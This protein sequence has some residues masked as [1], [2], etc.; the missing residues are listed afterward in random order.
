MMRAVSAIRPG[1]RFASAALGGW[2]A[3]CAGAGGTD[4]GEP[5]TAAEVVSGDSAGSVDTGGGVRGGSDAAVEDA[6]PA[7]TCAA[8]Q[9][10][11]DGL[12]VDKPCTAD[13]DCNP[14]DGPPAGGDTFY[15]P[16]GTCRAWQCA[17]DDHCKGGQKCNTVTYKCYQPQTGCSIDAQCVDD[18]AC[19][20]DTCDTETGNCAHAPIKGCCKVAADCD[21]QD[22]CTAETCSAG[23]CDWKDIAGCC[24]DAADCDDGD[25]CTTDSCASAGCK[26]VAA[27]GC[28]KSASQCNDADA[29]TTDTCDSK[30][31]S[32][33]HAL[34]GAPT[35]C[36]KAGDCSAGA[37]AAGACVGGVCS[38][39]PKGGATCCQSATTCPLGK[40]CAAPTCAAWACTT[41]PVSGGKEGPHVSWDFEGGLDGWTVSK[42]NATAFFHSSTLWAAHGTS[43]LRYGVPGKATWKAGLPNQGKALSPAFTVPTGA[44]LDA[45]VYF[46]G[47]PA[48]GVHL[49]GLEVVSGGVGTPVWS[50]NADLKGNTAG[51]WK[52]IQVD[53]SA[54]AGKS[55]QLRWWFDVSVA[56]PKEDGKGLVLDAVRI[57]APCP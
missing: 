13:A 44:K 51:A 36:S 46:D 23:K 39:A 15:C 24:N 55:V 33:V 53:L 1:I 57:L 30:T 37:C 8:H 50:K 22:S 12:C 20:N 42:D 31:Q 35:S 41:S 14:P 7:C 17:N 3:G 6:E 45:W 11:Q 19:T 28:C 38:Y 10:C 56:F 32:C 9:H 48:S 49:F 18:D 34:A 43:A 54:F 52:P 5:S 27:A 2:L 25:A 40:A 21:D 26:H 29:L 4:G 47:E 16:D